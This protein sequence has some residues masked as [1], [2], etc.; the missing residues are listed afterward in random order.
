[1]TAALLLAAVAVLPAD[2]MAMADRLFNRGRYEDAAAE[3]K[4]LVGAKGVAEDELL[5]RLAECDR[6][7]GRNE[8]ARIGYQA[9]FGKFPDSRYA[10]RSRFMYAMGMQGAERRRLLLELDS[11]RVPA[12]IRAA[13]LYYLGSETS[14]VDVLARCVKLEPKGKYAPYASLKI[15]TRLTSSEDPAQRRKGVETLLGIAFGGGQMADEALYLA[16]LQCYRDKKY[17]EAGSLFRRYRKMH[18][19][20]EHLSEARSMSVWSDFLQGRY[21]DAAA[22]CGDGETD[23][24]AYVRAASAYAMGDNERALALFRK[25][26]DDFPQGRYRAD[27]ELPIARI[28]FDAA[29]MSQDAPRAVESARR[30]F[31]LSK[32]ASDQLRLAWA[33]EKAGKAEAAVAEYDEIARKFQGSDEA[34]EALYRRA[35][36][37]AAEGNWS[38]AE[39]SL[40]EA[41]ASG[42]LGR[43]K[44]E[45]CYWRG[46]AAMKLGHEAEG[47]G[48]LREA[49]EAGIGLDESREARLMLAD[50]DYKSGRKDAAREAYAA[51]VREGACA[52]MSASRM[53]AVGRF[54]GGAEGEICAKELVKS[55]APEWRQT[56]WALLGE[57]EEAREAYAA[58]ISSY[59]K[60]VAEKARTEALAAATLRL[61]KLEFRAGD[62][63]KADITLKKSIELNASDARARAEA[64]V[65]LAKNA[66]GNGD[67]K[68]A[69]AYATAV[70]SLFDD[71]EMCAEARRILAAHPEV[72]K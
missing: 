55:D 32:L 7:A 47:A 71:E 62:F 43:R 65:T 22:A 42:K 49:I 72:S 31:G 3:Y 34:A 59:R 44:G 29:R 17:G 20:G 6:V 66:E 54:L 45:A 26:L 60:A 28:E 35:M 16:A 13:A 67:A 12:D 52:R 14:D 38:G 5:F 57:C 18:P 46:V 33:Y 68:S 15:G 41:V 2:R 4:S 23:D 21:A 8:A 40:A 37:A 50:H 63:D 10:S 9:I 24:L 30:S 36:L 1:M 56:G 69:V 27:A 11:D 61:G 19:K 48:F 53:F 70:V 39:L 51:L 25:Y 64:Y 58:A